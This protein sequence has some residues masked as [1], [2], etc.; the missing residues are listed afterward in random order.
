MA[1]PPR[2]HLNSAS[3]RGCSNLRCCLPIRPSRI[4]Q[5]RKTNTFERCNRRR[6]RSLPRPR[7][8][9]EVA[10]SHRCFSLLTSLLLRR[11]HRSQKLRRSLRLLLRRLR[12]HVPNRRQ[13]LQSAVESLHKCSNPR[14]SHLLRPNGQRHPR[15]LHLRLR[16]QQ[17]RLVGSLRGCFSLLRR[18]PRLR[19]RH[20]CKERLRHLRRSRHRAALEA[21]SRRCSSRRRLIRHRPCSGRRRVRHSRLPELPTPTG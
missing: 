2:Q 12:L 6:R 5:P 3:S 20:P 9:P 16:R 10:S 21:S 1:E 18:H 4:L 15:H 17:A 14:P 19:Q 7:R 11:H 13:S 8:P